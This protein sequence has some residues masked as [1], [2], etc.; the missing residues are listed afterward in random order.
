MSTVLLARCSSCGHLYSFCYILYFVCTSCI[1]FVLFLIYDIILLLWVTMSA[2]NLLTQSKNIKSN[3]LLQYIFIAQ[4]SLYN[5]QTSIYFT[6]V[7]NERPVNNNNKCTIKLQNLQIRNKIS[8]GHKL[9]RIGYLLP[10]PY[11]QIT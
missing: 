5:W 3:T 9:E 7:L 4:Q 8:F 2:F 1:Y 6:Q 10:R 11:T